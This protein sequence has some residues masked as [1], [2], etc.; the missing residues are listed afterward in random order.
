M[1]GVAAD[2]VLPGLGILLELASTLSDSPTPSTPSAPTSEQVQTVA[3]PPP[4]A[5]AA[6]A[7]LL[8]EDDEELKD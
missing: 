4:P 6:G 3:P 5:K 2:A 1:A 7:L 8:D